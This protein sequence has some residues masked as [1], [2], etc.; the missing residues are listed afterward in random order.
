MSALIMAGARG[1]IEI[2]V[3][4]Y[5]LAEEILRTGWDGLGEVGERG[6]RSTVG[7]YLGEVLA[8]LG[9]LDEAEALLDE[10]LGISTLDDWVTVSQ[11]RIGACV[12]RLG[13]PRA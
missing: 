13:S 1:S 6:M 5:E 12:R 11:V 9:R 2:A 3:G 10:A 4:E 8:R 7:G